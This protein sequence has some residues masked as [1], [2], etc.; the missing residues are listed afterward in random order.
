[1]QK[2]VSFCIVALYDLEHDFGHLLTSDCKNKTKRIVH[3]KFSF[4]IGIICDSKSTNSNVIF[5]LTPAAILE[6]NLDI[7]NCSDI[8]L[9]SA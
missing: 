4:K 6:A 3:N 2:R 8:F 5:L 7:S 1:M 9:I